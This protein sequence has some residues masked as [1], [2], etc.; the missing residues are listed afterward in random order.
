MILTFQKTIVPMADRWQGQKAPYFWM[1]TISMKLGFFAAFAAA[2][3]VYHC[4]TYWGIGALG[5]NTK[6]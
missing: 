3:A 4:E 5:F 2:Y 6:F 1:E